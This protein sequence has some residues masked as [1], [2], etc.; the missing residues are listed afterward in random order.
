M[1]YIL[2]GWFMIKKDLIKSCNSNCFDFFPLLLVISVA[3]F[4]SCSGPDENEKLITERIQYD[5]DIAN[6]DTDYDWWVR[7]IEGKNREALIKDL[8][9]S[10]YRG[11]LRTYDYFNNALD[12][13][14]IRN[15]W[16]YKD[17]LL[18]QRDTPPYAFFDTIVDHHLELSE[19]CRLRFLESWTIDTHTKKI[20]KE[21]LGIALIIKVYEDDGSLRGFMPL[22]WIYF[23]EDYP[24][25][26]EINF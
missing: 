26:M 24:E 6:M 16:N 13:D 18:L 25:K 8:I 7:N 5:V 4:Y 3:L 22:F 19:I 17:T 12:G 11:E 10:A 2:N 14:D 20:S 23:N 1:V 21:V 9:Q 15:K